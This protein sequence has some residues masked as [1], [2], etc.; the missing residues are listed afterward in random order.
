MIDQLKEKLGIVIDGEFSINEILCIAILVVLAIIL[1]VVII[2]LLGKG[3]KKRKEKKKNLFS[4]KRERGRYPRYKAPKY[5]REKRRAARA[6]AKNDKR[7][8]Y[9]KRHKKNR[10][11]Y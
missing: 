10:I 1:I 5:N 11:Y 8:R 4:G 7:N 9:S 2:Y 6:M 3:L